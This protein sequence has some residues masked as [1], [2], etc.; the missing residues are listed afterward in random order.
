[1]VFDEYGPVRMIRNTEYKYIHRYPYG[2]H[3]FYDLKADPDEN[4]NLIGRRTRSCRP[5]SPG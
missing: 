1:M 2:E 4:I 3:E 5:S